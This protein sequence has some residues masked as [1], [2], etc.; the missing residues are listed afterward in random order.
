[1]NINTGAISCG[2]FGALFREKNAA[3]APQTERG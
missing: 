3:P 1:M 2:I